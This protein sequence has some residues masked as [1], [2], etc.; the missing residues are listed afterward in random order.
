MSQRIQIVLP[1]PA[2]EQLRDQ[3]AA[4]GTPPSTLAAQYVREWLKGAQPPEPAASPDRRRP[5]GRPPWLEPFGGSRSWRAETWGSIIALYSRYPRALAALKDG[6]WS[7]TAHVETLCALAAWRAQL[8]TAGQDPREELAFHDRLADYAQTL[9]AE[10]GGVAGSW[11]PGAP[12]PEWVR[13]DPQAETRDARRLSRS[14]TT[15]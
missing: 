1:D 10:A 14:T 9:K 8:D 15:R 11:E 3:A 7:E 6:W 13:P 5:A 4:A 12:P 2:A